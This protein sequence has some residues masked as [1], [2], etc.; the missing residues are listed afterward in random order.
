MYSGIL[1]EQAGQE[2]YF[3]PSC[4]CLASLSLSLPNLKNRSKE[5]NPH[6]VGFF[7]KTKCDGMW[8]V[9]NNC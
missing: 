9:W 3:Q 7:V 8:T 1:C 5:V 6:P 2:V 4:G